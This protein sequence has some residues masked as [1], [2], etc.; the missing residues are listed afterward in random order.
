[1]RTHCFRECIAIRHSNDY[2]RENA[3][4]HTVEIAAFV[5]YH[6]PDSDLK[7]V[8]EVKNIVDSCYTPFREAYLNDMEGFEEEVSIEHLGEMLF[9]KMNQVLDD[10]GMFLERL[11]IGETP[12]RT[13]IV[14]RTV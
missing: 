13:Y 7:I 8:E 9:F 14:T 4:F 10:S 1:M 2:N 12:L 3:H 11:E 6:N 5:K